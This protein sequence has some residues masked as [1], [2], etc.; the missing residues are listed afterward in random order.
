[1]V[2]LPY[3]MQEGKSDEGSDSLLECS[4]PDRYGEI[5]PPSKRMK[6]DARQESS[7]GD[8]R[9]SIPVPERAGRRASS[10]RRMA[11]SIGDD[12][13][14][15]SDEFF[16]AL[17]PHHPSNGLT[18]GRF[19]ELDFDQD[20]DTEV[21][22]LVD[23]A[24]ARDGSAAAVGQDGA[25]LPSDGATTAA[26]TPNEI[27]IGSDALTSLGVSTVPGSESGMTGKESDMPG[28]SHDGVD[29]DSLLSHP[30]P[31]EFDDAVDSSSTIGIIEMITLQNF[32]CHGHLELRFGPNINFIIGSNG[33]MSFFNFILFFSIKSGL[34]K[35][36]LYKT[37]RR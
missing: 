11:A 28:D 29:T 1:M 37:S 10:L 26:P 15:P 22:A 14:D 6:L 24:S 12:E 19:T 7:D 16:V 25:F 2:R 31:E 27:S 36:L 13:D 21:P 17:A 9:T 35:T 34:I 5:P 3:E 33:S 18:S 20:V 23:D 4:P 30:P 32:M 8:E